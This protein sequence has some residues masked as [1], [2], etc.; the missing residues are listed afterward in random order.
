LSEAPTLDEVQN[1]PYLEFQVSPLGQYFELRV[2]RPRIEFD[3]LKKFHFQVHSEVS[4]TLEG[5][6]WVG[7]I[8]IDLSFH[9]LHWPLIG[10]A[11][12][13]LGK[14]GGRNYYSAFT[15]PQSIPDFHIPSHFSKFSE[16]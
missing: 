1:F 2:I 7:E 6:A 5:Q 14:A 13:I 3:P 11:F 8:R 4:N 12:A 15:P 9:H 10:N 16:N